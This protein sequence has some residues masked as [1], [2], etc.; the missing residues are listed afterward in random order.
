MKRNLRLVAVICMLVMSILIFAG[1]GQKQETKPSNEETKQSN[2]ETKETKKYPQKPIKMIVGF[3]V[4]GNADTSARVMQPYLQEQFGVTIEVE[5]RAGSGAAVARN[6]VYQQPAD[7]YTV[8]A[9]MSSD[10][11]FSAL[12]KESQVYKG[13]FLD[14]FVPVA[15]WITGDGSA[16]II[17]K[18]SS[19]QTFDEF[20]EASKKGTLNLALAGALGSSHHGVALIMQDLFG[21]KWN[22]IPYNSGAETIAAVRG[23]HVDCGLVGITTDAADPAT[24]KFLGTTASERVDKLQ[25]VPTFLELGYSELD[26]PV[27]YGA[28]VKAG[29]PEEVI[30]ILEEAFKKA[31][32]SE[33]YSKWAKDTQKPIGKFYDHK[34]W[35]DFM[36]KYNE[37]FMTILPEMQQSMQ[38]AQQK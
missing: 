16:L 10:V 6:H 2:Y 9:G 38:E 24:L 17:Q 32:N 20:I 1:C 23:G 15:S 4:G 31:Y 27:H 28:F 14:E 12:Y 35:T 21:V 33:K 25:G 11:I 22:L 26:I 37:Q 29:T 5:N 19:I 3:G 30:S 18:D 36:V 13:E 8:Y 7:G 34:M